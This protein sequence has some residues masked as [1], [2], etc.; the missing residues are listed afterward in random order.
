[1]CGTFVYSSHHIKLL[2]KPLAS[3]IEL[4]GLNTLPSLL[5]HWWYQKQSWCPRGA[6]CVSGWFLLPEFSPSVPFLS[7][8][9]SGFV[10][11]VEKNWKR[12]ATLE[13]SPGFQAVTLGPT[14]PPFA[15]SALQTLAFAGCAVSWRRV[16]GPRSGIK[17]TPRRGV[18]TWF[19][20]I[21]EVFSDIPQGGISPQKTNHDVPKRTHS[22]LGT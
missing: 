16:G 14:A 2:I 8:C 18:T 1:M 17:E 22:G 10:F 20:E 13:C 4:L 5:P 15:P 6:S 21:S 11:F 19:K 12:W 7:S 3:L 9:S